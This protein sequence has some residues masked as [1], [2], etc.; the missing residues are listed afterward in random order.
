MSAHSSSSL[1]RSGV[2]FG[3]VSTNFWFFTKPVKL[4]LVDRRKELPVWS[5]LFWR[6]HPD[7]LE[8]SPFA[9]SGPL[10]S[11]RVPLVIFAI[12]FTALAIR[13]VFLNDV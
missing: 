9:P 8:L 1:S 5:F 12:V 4:G 2:L 7:L 6:N 11:D 10:L 13:M 3:G